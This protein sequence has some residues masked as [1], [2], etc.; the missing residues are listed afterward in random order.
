MSG[1]GLPGGMLWRRLALVL[2]RTKVFL[3]GPALP[4]GPCGIACGRARVK[5]VRPLARRCS[6]CLVQL[7]LLIGWQ[8]RLL[9]RSFV[10]ASRADKQPSAAFVHT[11]RIP[12]GDPVTT[13]APQ[14]AIS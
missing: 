5:C 6:F 14:G 13:G 9:T 10:F 11:G 3:L 4:V 1:S 7:S 2:L 8:T 12:G